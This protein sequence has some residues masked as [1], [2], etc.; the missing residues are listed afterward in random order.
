LI[1]WTFWT[2]AMDCM[3]LIIDMSAI[4]EERVR[5][6]NEPSLLSPLF[7]KDF[8]VFSIFRAL[9]RRKFCVG[10]HKID[11]VAGSAALFFGPWRKKKTKV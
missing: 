9:F 10:M 2:W 7:H 8:L 1:F 11:D 3:V 6:S 5:A 4:Y